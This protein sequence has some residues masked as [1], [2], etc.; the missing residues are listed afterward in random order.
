MKKVDTKLK[1]LF[2][3]LNINLPKNYGFSVR[4]PYKF[5]KF[6]FIH[7]RLVD[8]TLEIDFIKEPHQIA[9]AVNY[10]K[11]L[12]YVGTTLLGGF[13]IYLHKQTLFPRISKLSSTEDKKTEYIFEG[14]TIK[15]LIQK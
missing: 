4:K 11:L 5:Y 9:I 8:N 7:W 6:P 2:K 10:G 12:F 13:S 15:N 14:F 1:S 3:E